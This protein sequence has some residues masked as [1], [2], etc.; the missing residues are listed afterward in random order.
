MSNALGWRGFSLA[1]VVAVAFAANSAFAALA[2]AGGSNALSVLTTRSAVAFIILYSFLAKNRV[3]RTLPQA[4]RV[5]VLALGLVMVISSYGL[6][7]AVEHMPVALAVITVY[8]YPILVA[9]SGW[10]SG[11]EIFRPRFAVALF[12]AF[13]G[14]V[15]AL[16]IGGVNSTAI[17][18]GLASIAAVGVAVLLVMNERLHDGHD[19]R[20][21][22]LHML[23]TATAIFGLASIVSGHFSFP[24]TP[25]GWVGFVSAP[26]CYAFAIVFL[27]VVLSMIGAMRT[28]LIMNIEPVA[29]VVLGYLLLAQKLLPLQLA[30]IALVVGAVIAIE[31]AKPTVRN[32]N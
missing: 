22:T 25:S 1:V 7:G 12:A 27:F 14:L 10:L 32:P 28:A 4:K 23:G 26:L 11:R 16:D 5:P 3:P 20:P 29:S 13:G 9:L 15:L 30:G 6:L 24:Q 2:Y 17:G 19:S 18:I 21:Y 31:A 8:T